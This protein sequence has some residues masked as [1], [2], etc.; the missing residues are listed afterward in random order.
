M[1]N[2][3]ILILLSAS[4][5]LILGMFLSSQ[6]IFISDLFRG[7]M[8]G[9][10]HNINPPK[11]SKDFEMNNDY[12]VDLYS[13]EPGIIKRKKTG[14]RKDYVKNRIHRHR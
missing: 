4:F 3:K 2:V 9:L 6:F 10:K 7:V 13:Q 14:G 1:K 12:L 11:I 8:S 5:A